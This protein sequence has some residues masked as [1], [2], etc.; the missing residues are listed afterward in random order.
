VLE[1]VVSGLLVVRVVMATG[2]TAAAGG[3]AAGGGAAGGGGGTQQPR[4]SITACPL[5]PF[6]L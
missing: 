1:G 4:A 2:V 5:R 6:F 3:G